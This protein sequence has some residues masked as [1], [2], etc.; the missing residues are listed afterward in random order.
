MTTTNAPQ[1]PPF[2][3]NPKCCFHNG[4]RDLWRFERNGFFTRMTPPYRVQRFRCCHCRRHFST[5]TFRLTYWL[6]R[7]R[8]LAP[9]YHALLGC[10]AFRQIARHHRVSP[11]T[12]LTHTARLGRHALLFHQLHRPPRLAEPVALD[13]FQSFEF[14]Q[15]F[16]TWFHV[17]VGTESHFFYGFTESELRRS[18]RMTARQKRRRAELEARLGRPDP[19]SIEREVTGLLRIL[20]PNPQ[21]LTLHTDD[22]ADYP[23]ACRRLPHLAID[24]QVTPGSDPRSARNPL[25]PVNLLDLL[26][27]HS[28]ANHKRE[29]IAFSKRRQSACDRLWAFL[30][31]RNYMKSFSEQKCDASPAMRLGLADRR[32]DTT[33]L[34]RRRLFPGRIPLPERWRRYYQ[35]EIPTRAIAH[36]P[37]RRPRRLSAGLSPLAASH[38]GSPD[39]PGQRPPY[40]AQSALPREP[41]RSP[42]PPQ[43]RQPQA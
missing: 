17:V 36:P 32:L 3:P 24:H 28:G 12:V 43:R 13:G 42:H 7:P 1:A 11:S 23:R 31:W 5:Q 27:R 16:P 34:L 8:L 18:G 2:C 39:H 10:S 26:I 6:K 33:D 19:R 35:R 25:F 37:H 9:I 20:A 29:S 15:Y 4:A 21:S 38:R 30:L 40:C 22:H 41:A 14:S